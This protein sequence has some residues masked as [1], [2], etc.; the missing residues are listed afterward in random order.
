MAWS[1]P[2]RPHSG[3]VKT[4]DLGEEIANSFATDETGG[5]YVVT[6]HAL[7]RLSAGTGRRAGRRLAY[8]V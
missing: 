1:A 7:H 3:E 6:T 5:T 8:G 2:S 4:L